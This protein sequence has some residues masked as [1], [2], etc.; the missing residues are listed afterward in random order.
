MTLKKGFGL[1][2]IEC[3]DFAELAYRN[4]LGAIVLREISIVP[5]IVLAWS[6]DTTLIRRASRDTKQ[7]GCVSPFE[8]SNR[9]MGAGREL[10]W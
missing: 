9:E 4:A 6:H 1:P 2:A 7:G 3:Q 10:I 5:A 8:L